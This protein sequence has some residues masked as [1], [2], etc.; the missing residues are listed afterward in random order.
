VQCREEYEPEPEILQ[1]L[2]VKK[3]DSLKLYRA[4]GCENCNQTGY[5][6]R[7]AVY[8]LLRIS[9]AIKQAILAEKTLEQ[10]TKKARSEGMSSLY[11][12]GVNKVLEG[13]TTVDE[14]LRVL[15]F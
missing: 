3:D 13:I 12:K 11:E 5:L 7:T 2:N 15:R 6:G 8:E 4:A 1:E 10:I 9:P 14:I